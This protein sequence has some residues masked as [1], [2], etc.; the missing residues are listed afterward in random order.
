MEYD[1][2]LEDILKLEQVESAEFTADGLFRTLEVTTKVIEVR[3]RG[4][5]W[6]LGPYKIRID[7]GGNLTVRN[8]KGTHQGYDHPYIWQYD[9]L[10]SSCSHFYDGRTYD[11]SLDTMVRDA[12]ANKDYTMAVSC[13]LE[14][15]NTFEGTAD[16][17][18][19]F[20]P[21]KE[22][23]EYGKEVKRV[24]PKRVA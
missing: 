19:A 18:Y 15:L 22:D 3:H 10:T 13:V 9:G 6:R 11:R 17:R 14:L 7:S 16:H 20:F 23:P 24:K 21:S 5:L 1:S 2:E 8:T 4:R 12:V